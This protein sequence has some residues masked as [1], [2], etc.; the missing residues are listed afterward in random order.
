MRAGAGV[1]L[2]TPPLAA[3]LV[4]AVVL[5]LV[6]VLVRFVLVP[7]V[8]KARTS[9]IGWD[10]RGRVPVSRAGAVRRRR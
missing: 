2:P 5:V 8:L 3:V 6:L 1:P 4:F 9:V 10:V 7:S